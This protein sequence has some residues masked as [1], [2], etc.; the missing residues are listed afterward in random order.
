MKAIIYT[1]YGSP[2]VLQ[3]KEVE[4]PTPKDNEV[5]VKI[6]AAAANP[7]DWHFMRGAPFLLRL[8]AGLQKPKN[9]RLGADIAGRVEAVGRNVTQFRPGDEV[10]GDVSGGALGGFAEYVCTSEDALALKPANLSFEA[11]AAAPVVAFTALQGLRDPA[12]P[13]SAD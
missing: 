1:R 4:K 11:A 10:F 2:D 7:L 8:E 9:T 5:L 12:G 13:E 6:H 3:L